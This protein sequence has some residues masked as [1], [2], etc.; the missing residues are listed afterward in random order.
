MPVSEQQLFF[1]NQNRSDFNVCHIMHST[2]KHPKQICAV[3]KCYDVETVEN[4]GQLSKCV[5]YRQ[6]SVCRSSD[7]V[8]PPSVRLAQRP[9]I[10]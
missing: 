8:F 10:E 6:I 2:S 5:L 4:E 7:S 3:R 1:Y 9:T